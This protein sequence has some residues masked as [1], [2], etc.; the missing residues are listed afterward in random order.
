MKLE[1][2]FPLLIRAGLDNDVNTIRAVTT[3]LI[4]KFKTTNPEIAYQISEALKYNGAGLHSA[5]SIDFSPSPQDVDSRM[6]LLVVKEPIEVDRPIFNEVIYSTI[7]TIVNERENFSKLMSM[8]LKPTSSIL[9]CGEPGVGK[10]LLAQYFSS[11][12]NFKFATLN[13]ASAVSSYLGKTGQNLKKSLDY[14]KEEPTLLLLDEFDA[15]AKRRDD[16]SDLGELKRVVN[17]LLKELEDWPAHSILVAATNHSEL[18]DKAIWRRFDI[19][20]DIPLPNEKTR[21]EIFEKMFEDTI[22]SEEI[23]TM[24]TILSE[25]SDGMSPADIE[26]ASNHAKKHSIMYESSIKKS[27]VIEIANMK[28]DKSLNFNK[29]FCRLAKDNLKMTYKEMSEILG[30]SIS[31]IQN[32]LK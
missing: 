2:F 22:Y 26:K 14:A 8:G 23:Y 20:I 4:R 15:I 31:A 27:I 28:N 18:L 12:F 17:V 10:T 1:D 9:L 5:R 3:K 19:S 21:R 13:M 32:Y 11:V 7:N 30:K 25:I 6:N 29:K 16:S 24:A